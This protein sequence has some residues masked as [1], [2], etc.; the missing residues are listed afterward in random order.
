MQQDTIGFAH[1]EQLMREA[2]QPELAI[3]V[4]RHHFEQ[5]A[6][7]ATGLMPEASIAPLTSLPDAE[8]LGSFVARGQAELDRLVVVKLN[9]GLGTSMGMEQAKSLL[10]VKDGRAFIDLIAEQ[11]VHLRAATGARLPLVL[12]DSFRTQADTRVALERHAE[13]LAG[14]SLPLSFLQHQVPKVLVAGLAPAGGVSDEGAWCPPG[15]GDLYPALATSGMLARLLADGY[16]WAFVSNA[17]NLGAT[18]D[19]TALGILGWMAE[20][21]LPFVM[22][23][24]DRTT[25]DRKGGHLAQ[26]L[27]GRLVLREVAQCPSEDA[28]SFQ[29]IERHRFFNTNNLWIDLVAVQALLD[30]RGGRLG[31]PLIRNT[32]SL[33]PTEASSSAVYQLE[34]AMGAAISLMAGAGAVRVPRSRFVPVK[35]TNDLLVL[36]SDVYTRTP[37]GHVRAVPERAGDLPIVDLDARYYKNI[38]DFRARIAVA[39]SLV[40]AQKLSVR[41]DVHFGAGVVVRG[42]ASL[43][44]GGEEPLF[45]THLVLDE[46]F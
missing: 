29:D 27:T 2:G 8:T 10:P 39:P 13:L 35:T 16:R 22:E 36:W 34:T 7:G 30:E 11:I 31:L 9:G 25:A 42:S 28:A 46:T 38:D 45:L 44:H 5:L 6:S 33:D 26:D 3:E 21:D 37:E 40:A 17:D 1:Y 23:C 15:H 32:K 4:F 24:A 14:Q 20:H 18:P 43:E 19:Q 41:G 12:M